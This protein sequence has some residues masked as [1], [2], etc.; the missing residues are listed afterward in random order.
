MELSDPLTNAALKLFDVARSRH[1][2]KKAQESGGLD[3]RT[4]R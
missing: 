2:R 3:P 1:A 4:F